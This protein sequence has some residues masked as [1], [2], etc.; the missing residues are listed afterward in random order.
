MKLT[1]EK[2]LGLEGKVQVFWA[3]DLNAVQL[4]FLWHGVEVKSKSFGQKTWTF[5]VL[6]SWVK[7]KSF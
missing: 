2:R 3:K 7:S 5:E 4:K 1:R 6:A